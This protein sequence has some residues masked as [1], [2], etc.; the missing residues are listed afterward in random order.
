MCFSNFTPLESW[1]SGQ[2]R[3]MGLDKQMAR[4]NNN[5]Q[6]PVIKENIK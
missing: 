4:G 6:L 3:A 5:V 1:K 2:R